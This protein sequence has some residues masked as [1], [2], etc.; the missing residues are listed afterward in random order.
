MRPSL[1]L[2]SDWPIWAREIRSSP[3]HQGQNLFY[4]LLCIEFLHQHDLGSEYVQILNFTLTTILVLPKLLDLTDAD[5]QPGGINTERN[6]SKLWLLVKSTYK[7]GHSAFNQLALLSVWQH[8]IYP[9][10]MKANLWVLTVACLSGFASL[11]RRLWELNQRRAFW[12]MR[13]GS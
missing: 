3:F 12:N 1:K 11:S 2:S 9:E 6:S 5:E 7:N 8:H 13:V 4:L 10:T